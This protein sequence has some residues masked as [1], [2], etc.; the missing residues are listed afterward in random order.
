MEKWHFIW[1]LWWVKAIA[2]AVL[3]TLG[4]TIG[5]I[6]RVIDHSLPLS[7]GR[8]VIE[9][10]AAGFVGL[11]FMLA[12]SAMGLSDQWTGVLVGVAG[13]LGANASIRI[14]ERVVF[15][16][17]GITPPSSVKTHEGDPR[18]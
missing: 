17:L 12:C 1:D 4:G 10:L 7:W 3:A 5:Y 6:M 8:A 9:G 16:K 13:W 18:V 2:Y 14:L 11:L 15:N